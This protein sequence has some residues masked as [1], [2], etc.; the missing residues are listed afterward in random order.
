MAFWKRL[1]ALARHRLQIALVR[2]H[3]GDRT[4][5]DAVY[6][7][8]WPLFLGL[9]RREL[10]ADAPDADDVA[11]EALLKLFAHIGRFDV[12]RDALAWALGII[13]FEIR[14]ARNR[15]LRRRETSANTAGSPPDPAPGPEAVALARDL[16]ATATAVLGRLRPTDIEVLERAARGE[17]EPGP[18]FRKRLERAVSRLR[19]A[20]RSAQDAD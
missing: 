17:R 4:A 11:Q 9:A 7:A 3:D 19:L 1:D 14:T 16:Q 8:L 6:T 13:G 20:W 12:E 10:G 18:T 2:L 5:F 15:T